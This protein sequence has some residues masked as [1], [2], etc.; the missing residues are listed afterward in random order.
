MRLCEYGGQQR[1]GD[2][3]LQLQNVEA[4]MANESKEW[5]CCIWWI[6]SWAQD[7]PGS[8]RVCW[9]MTKPLVCGVTAWYPVQPCTLVP[10]TVPPWC[11]HS[12]QCGEEE[13][14]GHNC[15]S[16]K[17]LSGWEV[18]PDSRPGRGNRWITDI[19]KEWSQVAGWGW[20]RFKVE[21]GG[22][23]GETRGRNHERRVLSLVNLS[24]RA[25]QALI[26]L[27]AW[28]RWNF[29]PEY[30]TSMWSV[31]LQEWLLS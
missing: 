10:C 15:P 3:P 27:P 22:N 31:W 9:G 28:F 29:T 12:D 13:E 21:E 2:L 8:A 16:C 20:G 19:N 14:G 25:A 18:A 17:D 6:L 30:F 24:R 1:L 11:A 26:W 23:K 5:R 7:Y 4:E